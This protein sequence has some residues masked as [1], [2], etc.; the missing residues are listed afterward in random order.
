[1]PNVYTG[2][3]SGGPLESKGTWTHDHRR[4]E[5]PEGG[6]FYVHRER[7]GPMAA[8]WKWYA[9]APAER[10]DKRRASMRAGE[11]E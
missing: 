8:H 3:I 9:D 10:N 5:P 11:G 7:M 1:M 6:G 4:Y 2:I